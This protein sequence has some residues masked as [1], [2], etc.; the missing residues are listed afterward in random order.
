[1]PAELLEDTIADDLEATS[2][3]E[4]EAAPDEE[5]ETEVEQEESNPYE[6]KTKEEIDALI[7]QAAKAAEAKARQSEAD[8]AAAK[9]AAEEAKRN[10][11]RFLQDQQAAQSLVN[12]QAFKS[13]SDGINYYVK[14]AVKAANEGDDPPAVST[15]WLNN[16]VAGMRAG[17]RNIDASE[18]TSTANEWFTTTH[19]D[20]E[21]PRDLL[22]KAA[23]AQ[24]IYGR[25]GWLSTVLAIAEAA[26]VEKGKKLGAAQ[27]AEDEQV[28][29]LEAK[30]GRQPGPTGARASGPISRSLDPLAPGLTEAERRQRWDQSNPGVPFPIR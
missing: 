19:P 15:E 30:N 12:G 9:A 17:L 27:K 22:V 23:Q 14:E 5:V 16:V 4:E 6:G 10:R 11:D 2:L 24:E 20:F 28:K 7:E 3:P 21:P 29:A 26:G 13:I 18:W 25:Q 1:M 8:K